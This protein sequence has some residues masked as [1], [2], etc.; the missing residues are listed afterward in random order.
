MGELIR[1]KYLDKLVNFQDSMF[2]K[3]ISGSRGVGKSH[4][5]LENFKN[6]LL[7]EGVNLD[8]I[9]IIEL[10]KNYNANLKLTYQLLT[11]TSTF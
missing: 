3:I 10:E 11:K 4:L 7:N 6:H 5:L 9:V 2:I 8:Q 1:K